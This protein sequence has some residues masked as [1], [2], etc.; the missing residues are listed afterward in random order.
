L[1]KHA[2]KFPA[3]CKALEKNGDEKN[4]SFFNGGFFIITTVI[5]IAANT[6]KRSM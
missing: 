1:Q 6:G 4:H 5:T 2:E 3:S